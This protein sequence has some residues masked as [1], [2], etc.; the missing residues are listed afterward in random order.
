[1]AIDPEHQRRLDIIRKI[2]ARISECGG[3]IDYIADN[4]TD[5]DIMDDLERDGIIE[6]KKVPG[7]GPRTYRGVKLT[8]RGW[9]VYNEINQ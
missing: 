1:M 8:D 5:I 6:F 4:Q 7:F 3:R 9:E 2:G